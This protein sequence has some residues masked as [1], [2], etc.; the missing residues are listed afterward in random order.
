[1]KLTRNTARALFFNLGQVALREMDSEVLEVVMSN[2]EALRKVNEEWETMTKELAK[3][4]YGEFDKMTDD[5]KKRYSSFME[6]IGSYERAVQGSDVD[7]AKELR[8]LAEASYPDLFKLYEKQISVLEKL[9]RAEIEVDIKP[10]DKA[11][12]A[13]GIIK[14]NERWSALGVDMVFGAMYEKPI[15]DKAND[16]AE[17][18]E[19]LK[20]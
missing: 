15:K 9:N 11:R 7:K 16:F 3:R 6:H 10:V 20:D 8:M 12:F 1:M 13:L 14:S 17:L 5:E 19:L 18:E 2:F 4:L